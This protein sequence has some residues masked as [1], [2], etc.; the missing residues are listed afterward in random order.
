MDDLRRRFASLDAIAVPDLRP[1][2]D[3]RAAAL[4]GPLT[5]A[6]V[7]GGRTLWQGAQRG[8]SAPSFAGIP[9]LLVV[10]LLIAALITVVAVGAGW[11]RLRTTVLPSTQLPHA[12]APATPVPSAASRNGLIAYSICPAS[13]PEAVGGCVNRIWLMNADGSGARELLPNEPGS[14]LPIAWLPDGSLV[15]Q[16]QSAADAGRWSF[17]TADA[18]GSSTAAWPIESL[19]PVDAPTCRATA[20][21][22]AY[23]AAGNRLAY[24]TWVP[25]VDTTVEGCRWQDG[26]ITVLDI[27]TGRVTPLEASRIPG[28]LQCCDGYYHPTWSP[29][30]TRLAFATPPFTPWVIDVDGSNA[31]RLNVSGPFGTEPWWS[32]DGSTIG[33]EIC[34]TQPTLYLIGPGGGGAR[35]VEFDGCDFHWTLDGRIVFSGYP[36]PTGLWVMDADGGNLRR[37]DDSVAALTEAGCLI[38]PL[39]PSIGPV[40]GYGLWQPVAEA[41]P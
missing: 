40:N 10:G 13:D 14:Q 7:V 20:R 16:T 12:S 36:S 25:C 4:A 15:Y 19:C 32:P 28:P 2:I 38:C 11:F 9:M 41:Q 33:S 6:P 3:R 39:P 29:D 22:G 27:A 35:T 31:H 37:L 18:A 1:A 5:G 26:T 24:T 23:S 34:G 17:R 30:G 8:A 21:E